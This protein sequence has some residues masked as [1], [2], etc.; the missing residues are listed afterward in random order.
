MRLPLD[1]ARDV[2]E[3][4]GLTM[5]VG[6]MTAASSGAEHRKLYVSG[7]RLVCTP[8]EPFSFGS[9]FFCSGSTP[10]NGVMAAA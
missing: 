4:L 6:W 2:V 8:Q 3:R 9:R 1:D 10:T 5:S 7:P